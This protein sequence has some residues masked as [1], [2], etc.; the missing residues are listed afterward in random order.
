MLQYIIQGRLKCEAPTEQVF[1]FQTTVLNALK[2]FIQSEL[3]SRESGGILI[4]R[5][6]IETK[7]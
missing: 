6:D 4:G 5:T 3:D 2:Q 7:A 1:V